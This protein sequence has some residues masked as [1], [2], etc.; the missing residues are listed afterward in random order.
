MNSNEPRRCVPDTLVALSSR[1]YLLRYDR[2][3]TPYVASRDKTEIGPQAA[4]LSR[5][6]Q[7]VQRPGV[8]AAWSFHGYVY[9]RSIVP[10]DQDAGSAGRSYGSR[11]LSEHSLE[12]NQLSLYLAFVTRRTWLGRQEYTAVVFA[13]LQ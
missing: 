9:Q 5:A 7:F 10:S 1:R 13:E 6:S 12:R 8:H 2:H 11:V 3:D 4:A